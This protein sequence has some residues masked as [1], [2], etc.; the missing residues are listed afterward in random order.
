MFVQITDML[1]IEFAF[2]ALRSVVEKTRAM[3]AGSD[4]VDTFGVS[5]GLKYPSATGTMAVSAATT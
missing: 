2:P 5:T 1:Y 4:A 3:P